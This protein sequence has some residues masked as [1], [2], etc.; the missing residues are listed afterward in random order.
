MRWAGHACM[1]DQKTRTEEP[2]GEV[3]VNGSVILKRIL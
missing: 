2:I 3:T 1:E